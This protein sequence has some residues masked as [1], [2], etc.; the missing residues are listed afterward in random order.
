MFKIANG[1][2]AVA[3]LENTEVVR[4]KPDGR[5]FDRIMIDARKV[6]EGLT[7]LA[8]QPSDRVFVRSKRYLREEFNVIVSGEVLQ[9][10][11]YAITRDSTKLS[12]VIRWAGGF[13][14][15]AAIPECK[16]FR[17]TASGDPAEQNPDYE[18]LTEMRLSGMDRREREYFN[19]EATI[20]RGFV[21]V[22]F[23]RLFLDADSAA[24]VTLK[25]GDFIVVPARSRA[26]YVY[27]QV[28]NPG[29]LTYMPGLDYRYYVQKAGGYS[30]AAD[31]GNVSLIKAGTKK[32]VEADEEPVE[33]GDAVFVPRHTE[34]ERIRDFAYYFEL[35]RDIIS[36][37]TTA[38]TIYFLIHQANK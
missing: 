4:F 8:L 30:V 34:P 20:R 22:D 38:A 7:D 29:Y 11:T 28:S 9:P 15:E 33:E 24:D 31:K 21:S 37:G 32:W 25:D 5:T 2:Q 14:P 27:G 16:I 13:T 23:R 19:Y 10:G 17:S 26:V 35:A 36:V 6:L 1:P 18:R 12:E 3:D